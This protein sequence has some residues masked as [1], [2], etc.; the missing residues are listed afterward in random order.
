MG[1][2]RDV[3]GALTRAGHPARI[4]R[5]AGPSRRVFLQLAGALP[6]AAW[7]SAGCTSS[8]PRYLTDTE[9]RV[10]GACA[11]AIFPPDDS[12]PGAGALGAVDFIDNLL[13]AFEHD[14][15][16]I[17][18][19]G[20]F[21]NRNPYPAADGSPSKKFPPDQFLEYLPLSRVQ[22]TGW[23]LRIY[24]SRGVPGGGPND[25]VLGPVIGL[26]DLLRDGV[27]AAIAAFPMPIDKADD[28]FLRGIFDYVPDDARAQIQTLVLQ[29]LFA[30]PEYGGNRDGG[31]WR[32]IHFDGDSMPLGY[33]YI[34]PAT[35]QIRDRPDAPVIGPT[36]TPDPDPMD[37]EIIALFRGAVTI[38]GGKQFY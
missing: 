21:S 24:G 25:A 19:A 16:R 32:V 37:D 33:T 26:R 27:A 2:N 14:P 3:V 29:S 17:H 23:Q 34:D 12:G 35:S 6:A 18:A 20:P 13:T 30:L 4:D 1:E 22:R 9:R 15:P 11:D 7:L 8:G 38:L 5:L 10:L 31:G 28:E 36:T